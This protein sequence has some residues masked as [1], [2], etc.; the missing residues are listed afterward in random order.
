MPVVA[1]SP[2]E[3]EQAIVEP[4]ASTG[5]EVDG[6]VVAEIVAACANRQGTLPLLQF[7][8]TEL[9]ER[10][11]T[12]KVTFE[13]YRRLGGIAGAIAERAESI[14][15]SLDESGQQSTRR[16]FLRLVAVGG[17]N[18]DVRRRVRR[19]ELTAVGEPRPIDHVLERF[20]EARLLTFDR[21]P[22]TREQTVEV[23]HESLLGSWPRL[24]DWIRDEGQGLRVRS[25]LTTAANSWERSGRDGGDLYRG[26]RLAVAEGFADD[27]ADDLTALEHEFVNASITARDSELAEERAR[28]AQQQVTNRRLRKSLV[29][30]VLVLA[31]ATTAGLIA[32]VQRNRARSETAAAERSRGRALSVTAIEA[33][34]EDRQPRFLL[35]LEAGRL[36]D[37]IVTRRALLASLGGGSA[38][39]RTVIP[40]PA[41][42]YAA[43]DVTPDGTLAVAKRGDGGIDVV[44]LVARNVVLAGLPSPPRSVQ[45]L[46]LYP[47]GSMV[48]SAGIPVDNV[49]VA[50][51]DVTTGELLV[52][53][54]GAPGHLHEA[55][56]SPDGC[57]SSA[58]ADPGGRIRLY[59][60]GEW[61]LE[62]T[63]DI[64]DPDRTHHHPRVRPRRQTHRRRCCA[65][66]R[67]TDRHSDALFARCAQRRGGDRADRDRCRG[68]HRPVGPGWTRR[69]RRREH[70]WR[71]AVLAA[72][73]RTDR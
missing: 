11:T 5:V 32:F 38:F 59:D 18:D 54:P 51:Y 55:R 45:G 14:F 72:R 30:I 6:R 24:R 64:G 58:V 36:D 4:A 22:T 13:D 7:C 65:R 63:F 3:L 19:G 12:S 16:V 40:T 44:D 71:P 50:V 31:S 61:T 34:G 28:A 49:A 62:S 39:S 26:V 73:I 27:H 29:G 56:F 35:S 60:V 37:S 20:G 67:C 23:A 10:R 43:L 69:D 2:A 8:M 46:D 21:D 25:E 42:D 53:L 52:E 33:L 66:R 15:E 70:S 47:D 17:S 57:A 41:N 1:M 68:N 48:A 9:F